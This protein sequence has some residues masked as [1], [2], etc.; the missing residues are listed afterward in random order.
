MTFKV[1]SNAI[2]VVRGIHNTVKQ[3]QFAL[4]HTINTVA[5]KGRDDV[6]DEMRVVFDRPTNWVLNSIQV[7]PASIAKLEATVKA[8]DDW[9]G[10]N[11]LMPQVDGGNRRNKGFEKALRSAGLM[12]SD[13]FV[14]PA[15]GAKLDNYGNMSKGQ[16]VQVMSQ[17]QLQR[18]GGYESRASNSAASKRSRRRQGVAYFAITKQR[19]KLKPGIY[20]RRDFAK[21]SAVKPV[22]MFVRRP[23]YKK[24]LRFNEVLEQ[25]VEKNFKATYDKMVKQ[26]VNT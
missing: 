9:G 25:S 19:G 21:G 26:Y 11:I 3:L 23:S 6:K 12:A 15:A 22:Y 4:M 8:K 16:V 14:V 24:R 13:Q 18:G 1:S 17:L 20:L 2:D 7:K 10:E 5:Y